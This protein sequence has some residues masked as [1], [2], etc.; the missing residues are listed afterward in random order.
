MAGRNCEGSV[1][2][3][4]FSD[5]A[6][7]QSLLAT[8]RERCLSQPVGSQVSPN[9]DGYGIAPTDTKVYWRSDR[10]FGTSSKP[11]PMR[12][13]QLRKSVLGCNPVGWYFVQ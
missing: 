8:H 7:R 10:H 13:G 4:G 3:G 2:G 9:R 5:A 11:H 6:E 12:Y 1:D